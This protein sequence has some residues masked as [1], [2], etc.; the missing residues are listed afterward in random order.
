MQPGVNALGNRRQHLLALFKRVCIEIA[1]N[2]LQ[3]GVL[4][5]ALDLMQMVKALVAVGKLRTL[6]RRHV[7]MKRHRHVQRVHHHP[8]RR[9]GVHVIADDLH[10]R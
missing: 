1:N 3:L 8:F 9:A 4:Y 5:R 10:Y 2:V 7:G 6:F